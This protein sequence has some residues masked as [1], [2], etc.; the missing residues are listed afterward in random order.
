MVSTPHG[1]YI[2][3]DWD[4]DLRKLKH[5]RWIRNKI[6]HD[7]NCSEQNMCESGDDIWIDNF[8]LRIINQT[9]PLSLYR[10]ATCNRYLENSKPKYKNH[11]YSQQIYETDEPDEIDKSFEPLV[12][13]AGILIIVLVF[14]L[15]FYFAT[16]IIN[17]SKKMYL[18]FH[19]FLLSA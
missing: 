8:Y 5:Y 6:V 13:L 4:D 1:S 11:K 14:M 15:S 2:V 3:E 12:W 7:F 9:D 18:I 16:D 10:K 19:D 17:A